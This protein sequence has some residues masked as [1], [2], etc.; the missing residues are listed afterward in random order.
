MFRSDPVSSVR[1][2]R[3]GLPGRLTVSIAFTVLL[4]LVVPAAAG[5]L[6]QAFEFGAGA[7]I[8]FASDH[9][10]AYDAGAAFSFGYSPRV[11]S[12]D[13]WIIVD[14]GV[15]RSRGEEYRPDPTFEVQDATYWLIPVSVGFRSNLVPARYRERARLYLGVA[16]QSVFTRLTLPFDE[17]FQMT[18]FGG[19]FELRPEIPIGA[20]WRVWLRQRLTFLAEVDYGAM[21]NDLDYSGSRL[22][23]GV[24]YELH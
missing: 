14:V 21:V 8:P 10:Q 23:V 22:L 5:D 6:V 2:S 12:S 16:V 20:S 13:V 17:G 1:A 15:I 19:L 11:S 9:R 3:L 7:A 4:A 18:T 24:S